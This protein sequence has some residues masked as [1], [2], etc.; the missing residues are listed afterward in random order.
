LKLARALESRK[1]KP[2]YYVTVPT[3][4]A[5]LLRRVLTTRL[6]DAVASRN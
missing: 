2:R 6:L 3:Y 1:P 4:A 5:A